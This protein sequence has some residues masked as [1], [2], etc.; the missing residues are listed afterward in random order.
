MKNPL[1]IPSV[2]DLNHHQWKLVYT[3]VRKYQMNYPQSIGCY[4]EMYKEL[5]EILEVLYP[6]AY[7][8]SYLDIDG[9]EK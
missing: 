9:D 5:G 6:Y 1:S 7:S 4:Q 2:N 8:E 3:A